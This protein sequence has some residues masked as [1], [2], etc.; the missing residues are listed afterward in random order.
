M[1][2]VS[3]FLDVDMTYTF[4][5]AAPG[6]TLK[7]A[8]AAADG[9]GPLLV[10]AMA[11]HRRA[12]EDATILATALALPFATLQVMAAIH[13][14]ALKLWLKGVPLVPRRPAASLR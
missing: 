9:E 13:W 8:I 10:A 3:P 7:L 1:L 5:G 14:E 4:S 12:L 2:Y 6:E 11:A